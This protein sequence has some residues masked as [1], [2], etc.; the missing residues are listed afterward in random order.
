[1]KKTS[2]WNAWLI[3]WRGILL[4]WEMSPHFIG[5]WSTVAIARG[6]GRTLVGHAGHA[7]YQRSEHT[8]HHWKQMNVILIWDIVI[9]IRVQLTLKYL[10][11]NIHMCVALVTLSHWSHGKWVAFISICVIVTNIVTRTAARDSGPRAKGTVLMSPRD[12]HPTKHKSSKFSKM[13]SPDLSPFRG[14]SVHHDKPPVRSSSNLFAPIY[15][16]F[17]LTLY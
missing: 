3:L 7:H 1:M 10:T 2:S 4:A 5:H 15:L 6:H 17:I 12:Q 14:K 9:S 16:K 11:S 13:E 8:G